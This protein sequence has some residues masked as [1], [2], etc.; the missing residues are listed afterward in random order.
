MTDRRSEIAHVAAAVIAERGLDGAS[1][2]EI[3]ARMGATVGT[4]THHFRDRED[5]LRTTFEVTVRAIR[6]RAERAARGLEGVPLLT[7]LLGE[8]LPTS[9]T[10]RVEV[11]VWLAFSLSA[12]TNEEHAQ[13]CARLYR[14]WEDAVA[15]VLLGLNVEDERDAARLLM[16][17]TDGIALRAMAA[18]TISPRDQERLLASAIARVVGT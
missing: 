5:L 14:E 1:M 6:D 2:R 11:A 13:L 17:A 12:T 4:L 16:A 3:A 15:A 10:R 7:A 18:S 9:A 8:G